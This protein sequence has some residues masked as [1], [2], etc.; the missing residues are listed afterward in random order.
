MTATPSDESTKTSIL[1]AAGLEFCHAGFAGARMAAIAE[2]AE[3][4]KALL[5]YYFKN[6]DNLYMEVLAFSMDLYWKGIMEKVGVLTP[7]TDLVKALETLVET[8]I[9]RM[10]EEPDLTRI[11]LQ[12]LGDGGPRIKCLSEKGI[13]EDPVNGFL[14]MLSHSEEFRGQDPLAPV[15]F[16]V[17]L[18]GM[19]MSTWHSLPFYSKHLEIHQIP[20]D[21]EFLKNR[22]E[23]IQKTVRRYFKQ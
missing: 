8:A 7:E 10:K 23:E 19:I 2:R 18:M 9:W 1:R 5:H 15:Q 6:K 3:V 20:F 21:D 11:I 13:C 4:N 17:N 12:E 16:F 14:E 22:I